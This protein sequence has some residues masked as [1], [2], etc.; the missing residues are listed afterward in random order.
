MIRLLQTLV[1]MLSGLVLGILI[2]RVRRLLAE[3]SVEELLT[4][5]SALDVPSD[6][7]LMLGVFGAL[8]ASAVVL[9][10]LER[11]PNAAISKQVCGALDELIAT[12]IPSRVSDGN[13]RVVGKNGN[14]PGGTTDEADCADMPPIT[15]FVRDYLSKNL[16]EL[17]A[18]LSVFLGADGYRDVV[19]TTPVGD[20]HILAEQRGGELV[21]INI[22]SKEHPITACASLL[23][24]IA[25]V[26]EHLAS[27]R[28]VRGIFVAQAITDELRYVVSASPS[29]QVC[30]FEL[31]VRVRDDNPTLVMPSVTLPYGTTA[32]A[33]A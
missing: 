4:Q 33:T 1:A 8:F 30:E 23:G 21:V 20:I 18:G 22:E 2:A 9:I 11:I 7:L 5:V 31:Q 25:W 26:K 13:E 6:V 32:G 14:M 16:E 28:K 17:D 29:I 10:G 15:A 12:E 27:G 24:Q 19:R 3:G